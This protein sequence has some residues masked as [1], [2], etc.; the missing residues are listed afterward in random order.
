VVQHNGYLVAAT[1]EEMTNEIL[2]RMKQGEV[3]SW[4]GQLQAKQKYVR[5]S[6]LGTID[7]AT[8]KKRLMPLA[9]EQAVKVIEAIGLN[10]LE[11]L[12]YSCG[13]AQTDFAQ[14]FRI[15][16]DGAPTGIFATFGDKGITD[17]DLAHFPADSFAALALSIDGKKVLDEATS[18]LIQLDPNAAEDMAPATLVRLSHCITATRMA[19]YRV[20]SFEPRFRILLGLKR[21]STM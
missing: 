9:D 5:T 21:Q 14:Q 20:L 6:A 11:R 10:N 4:L 1:S 2:G 7:A 13:Y 16:F 8:L 15:K 3:A 19:S 18:I 12:D 17:K